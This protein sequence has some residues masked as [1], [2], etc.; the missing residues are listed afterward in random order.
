MASF[1]RV[2]LM[3]NLTRDPE[4]RYTGGGTAVVKIAL[5]V[6]RRVKKGDTWEDEAHFFDAVMFGNRAEALSKYVGKG[7]PLLI[8]GELVQN[9]W[10]NQQGEKRSK[11]EV[12][13]SDFS[14][15]SSR[16]E[17][18]S[19]RSSEPSRSANVDD[20]PPSFEDDDIP[21]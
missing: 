14:F 2:I 4:I 9:R 15:V 16:G 10:E 8:E 6:N 13:I 5:A 7:D 3:G 17:G 12:R 1:N 18:G 11:V 19:R 21:F 20:A